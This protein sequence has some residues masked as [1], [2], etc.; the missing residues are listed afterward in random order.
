MHSAFLYVLLGTG[1][2][3][4]MTMLGAGIVFFFKK[5]ISIRTQKIFLGFA[6]GVMMAASVWSLL[7]PAIE[8]SSHLGRLGFIPAAG[9]FLAGGVFIGAM[10]IVFKKLSKKIK[11]KNALMI[12]AVTMHNIPEGMSVGVA[13]AMA[14]LSKDESIFYAAIVFAFGIGIQ[15]F[16][17][18]AAISLPLRNEGNSRLK[19][20]LISAMSGVV[21][22][23]F[24]LLTVLVATSIKEFMPWMLSIAA[25]AM[26]YVVVDEL[27]PSANYSEDSRDNSRVGTIAIISGFLI[28]MI[29]DVAFAG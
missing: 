26:I 2:T 25:G 22:P 3:F 10:D 14:S 7:I 16:P 6:A 8:G 18:G 9:G 4:L 20:F 21:E 12:T 1:F 19:S 5:E 17:E 27:I 11:S 23:V 24:G 28:M 13:F 29:L 15:N